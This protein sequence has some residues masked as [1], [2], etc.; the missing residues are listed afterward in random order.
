MIWLGETRPR[1]ENGEEKPGFQC[2]VVVESWIAE[3]I[4]RVG[5]LMADRETSGGDGLQ[6]KKFSNSLD[7]CSV[8][9]TLIGLESLY[10][11][12]G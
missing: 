3:K 11:L 4:S 8:Y 1:N 2:G 9:I 7:D 10:I 6:K 12:Q 5:V